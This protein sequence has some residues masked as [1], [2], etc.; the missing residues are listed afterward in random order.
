MD[1]LTKVKQ[2]FQIKH[3]KYGKNVKNTHSNKISFS[4]DSFVRDI[5]NTL[6]NISLAIWLVSFY[7]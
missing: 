3:H 7:Q 1:R 4:E 6:S 2:Y 5:S